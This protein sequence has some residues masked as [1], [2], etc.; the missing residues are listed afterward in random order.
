MTIGPVGSDPLAEMPFGR[1]I[2]WSG[3]KE[4]TRKW[5]IENDQDPANIKWPG[6]PVPDFGK[7]GLTR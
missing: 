6:I 7:G 1:T 2:P 3:D 4:G 5:A